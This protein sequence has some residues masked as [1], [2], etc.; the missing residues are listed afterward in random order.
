MDRIHIEGIEFHGFHGVPEAER[1]IGHR[2]RV[3][4]TLELNLRAAGESDDLGA[5]IDYGEAARC[6]V[7]IGT[8]ASVQLVESLAERMA[9]AL[10]AGFAA[11]RAVEVR[12]AKLQPPIPLPVEACAV[13]IRRERQDA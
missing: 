11:I 7:E 4:L 8:G 10:L 13:Q 6:A 2:Y 12:V 5:T 9:A 3:D 1:A